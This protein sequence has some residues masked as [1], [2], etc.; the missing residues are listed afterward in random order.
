MKITR[1]LA[2]SVRRSRPVLTI[3]NFDGQHRGHQALLREV[4]ATAAAVH[5]TAMAL[6]FEPHPLRVLKPDVDLRFL[7]SPEEKLARFREVGIQEVI[8]LEFNAALAALNPEE[9]VFKILRDGLGVCDLFV[10]EGFAFGK[11]RAG[12]MAE[13]QRLAVLAGFE[14]H[15][16]PAVMADGETV[17]SSRIRRLIQ[18]GDVRA[19]ARCLGRPYTLSGPVGRGEQRGHALGWPTAN[20]PLPAERVI[21]A[22]GVY[23]ARAGVPG[24]REDAVAYIGTR[25]TFGGGER[26]LEA[27]VLGQERDLYGAELQVEFVDRLRGDMTFA[28]PEELSA[29]IDRDVLMARERLR[30]DALTGSS[31]AV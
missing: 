5:G 25:P 21:P 17:S 1:G 7:T 11:D 8:L 31:S 16:V 6:T 13:L 15:P 9:F 4:V 27:Y 22:D 30:A 23:A 12:Q 20:V 14:V 24:R 3:G 18:E 10:G 29:R 26:L 19:A 2:T 28:T